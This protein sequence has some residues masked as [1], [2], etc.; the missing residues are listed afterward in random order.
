VSRLADGQRDIVIDL[1]WHNK[2]HAEVARARGVSRPAVSRALARAYCHGR[3]ELAA[4]QSS[5]AA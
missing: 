3:T 1:F 5:L 4:Y 2:S